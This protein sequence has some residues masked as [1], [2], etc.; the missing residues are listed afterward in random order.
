MSKTDEL[1]I[2]ANQAFLVGNDLVTIRVPSSETDG[3]YAIVELESRPGSAP[4]LHRHD[5]A[6]TYIV[7]DGEYEF[8]LERGAVLERTR[9]VPGTVLHVPSAAAHA[10]RTAGDEPA[11]MLAVLAPGGGEGFF[12]EVGTAADT[13]GPRLDMREALARYGITIVP[14]SPPGGR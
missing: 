7:L 6:E 14:P 12:A 9:G 11:R 4:P 8:A 13:S 5:F 1:T 10:F 3:R 2:A